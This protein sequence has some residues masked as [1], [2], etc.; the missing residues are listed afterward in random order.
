MRTVREHSAGGVI[1]R[2]G[3]G[4]PEGAPE[5]CLIATEGFRH[6]QLPKGLVEA[7]EPPQDT[8]VREV[9]EET[10][11]EGEVDGFLGR[12]EYWYVRPDYR[13][14]GEHVRV[15]KEVDFFLMRYVAGS[16]EDHDH[17]VD[18]ARWFPIDEALRT[19]SFEGERDILRRARERILG[20][21]APA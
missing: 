11:L 14:T 21:P 17:E 19:L 9:R 3:S 7:G 1:Y 8:A 4:S 2:P 10:G 16:T 15:H 12:I 6:W 20:K 18:D 13:K 5:V